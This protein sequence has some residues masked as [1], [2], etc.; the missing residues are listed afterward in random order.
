[1][2]ALINLQ[3]FIDQ[4]SVYEIS[5]RHNNQV[6]IF[7]FK[8]NDFVD[9]WYVEK[10][11]KGQPYC[12]ILDNEFE[13]LDYLKKKTRGGANLIVYPVHKVDFVDAGGN[14]VSV[15]TTPL[16]KY[17]DLENVCQLPI[18]THEDMV[19][20]I[21]LARQMLKAI[22]L[23]HEHNVLH[24]DIKPQN[25]FLDNGDVWLGDFGLAKRTAGNVV[26]AQRGYAGTPFYRHP[27]TILG[28]M[29][30][31]KPYF[32]S[33]FDDI[34][35]YG[36]T[37]YEL[38]FNQLPYSYMMLDEVSMGKL[39]LQEGVRGST[40]NGLDITVAPIVIDFLD[41]IFKEQPNSTTLLKHQIFESA[42]DLRHE[43]FLSCY[44]PKLISSVP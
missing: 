26:L 38:F 2:Q 22:D 43:M 14:D 15:L 32:I 9:D 18:K 27:N 7:F 36:I 29:D 16:A 30:T 28:E 4:D 24:L 34:W 12:S 31:K 37:I 19:F 10:R 17:G 25:F 23:I 5:S 11:A 8:S 20:R 33:E 35:A 13:I 42:I 41:K 6:K 39:L 21:S 44:P 1:M 40:D 3:Q